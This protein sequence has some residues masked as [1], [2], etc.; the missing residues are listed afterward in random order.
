MMK[1]LSAVA[2]AT[3]LALGLA[4]VPAAATPYDAT[5]SATGGGSS[6]VAV[7][8]GWYLYAWRTGTTANGGGVVY[9]RAGQRMDL[10]NP[11]AVTS[12]SKF[13]VMTSTST[14]YAYIYCDA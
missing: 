5:C 2:C 3:A 4:A 12:S 1:K 14:T 7:K 13:G 6:F 8:R 9:L 11:V 10:S